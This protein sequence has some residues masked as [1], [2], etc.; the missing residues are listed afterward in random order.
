MT[1][2]S[3]KTIGRERT[4]ERIESLNN[5]RNRADLAEALDE[6]PLNG[7]ERGMHMEL[8][9][10][11]RQLEIERAKVAAMIAGADRNPMR[12]WGH[13]VERMAAIDARVLAWEKMTDMAREDDARQ[14]LEDVKQHSSER[15]EWLAEINAKVRDDA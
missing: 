6:S 10:L 9:S 2:K 14:L 8:V 1:E 7:R 3:I 11:R 4:A 5:E 15:A 13:V 12:P